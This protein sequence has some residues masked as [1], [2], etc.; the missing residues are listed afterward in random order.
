MARL[1]GFSTQ[2]AAQDYGV[3]RQVAANQFRQQE[4]EA[5]NQALEEQLQKIQD[6][7]SKKSKRGNFF[8]GGFGANLL[9]GLVFGALGPAGAALQLLDSVRTGILTD[10]DYKKYIDNLRELGALDSDTM[11]RFEGT[12]L[13]SIL[14]NAVGQASMEGEQ[15][16]Q[17][18]R[19]AAKTGNILDAV[20]SGI[21][22]G[23]QLKSIPNISTK[24]PKINKA[25]TTGTDA[26]KGILE[27]FGGKEGE[28]L[29]KTAKSITK[30]VTLGIPRSN[31][32]ATFNPYS[33]LRA[34]K[35]PLIDYL[36]GQP[37]DISFSEIDAPRRRIR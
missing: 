25:V 18:A 12:P 4:T 10:Q 23:G 19:G 29:S 14:A 6:E 34:G 5:A 26:L 22:L 30:P 16:L 37:G 36:I 35:S 28:V 2:K 20:L 9:K 13:E 11:K 21:S 1:G 27:T 24:M 32:S 8:G 3:S 15:Y 7:A 33:L 17:G 31:I